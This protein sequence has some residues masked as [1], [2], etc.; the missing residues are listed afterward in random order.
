MFLSINKIARKTLEQ[1]KK[2][3]NRKIIKQKREAFS[4]PVKKVNSII[5]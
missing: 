1:S 3:E 4:S 2:I 5:M